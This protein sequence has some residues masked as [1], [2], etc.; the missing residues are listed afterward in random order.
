MSLEDCFILFA[1]PVRKPCVDAELHK[2]DPASHAEP[3][4]K[5]LPFIDWTTY[6]KLFALEQRKSTDDQIVR[7]KL[8]VDVIQGSYTSF[9]AMHLD[10]V[11]HNHQFKYVDYFF[12]SSFVV[13]AAL[14]LSYVLL[15]FRNWMVAGRSPRRT[16]GHAKRGKI[17]G[18]FDTSKKPM[19]HRRRN[20]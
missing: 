17:S 4:V 3:V 20:G 15:T 14:I 1:E 8:P 12:L 5:P 13:F 9:D 2:L 6:P 10:R 19:R 18:N 11:F 7:V 16:S